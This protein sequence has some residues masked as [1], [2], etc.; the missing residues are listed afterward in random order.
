[1]DFIE[2]L[3]ERVNHIPLP[4]IECKTGY[5]GEEESF[6]V[7]PL[8][9]SRVVMEY[10]D[11]TT[12]QQLNFEFAMKSKLQSQIHQ[13]LWLV[14]SELE[15][16]K[17]LESNDGSFEFDE[18]VITNKPFINQKD[19]QGWFVFLLDVQATITVFKESE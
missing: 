1:M 7:Y 6:V 13:T 15:K 8:P 5:L 11:G 14:Q 3:V 2:R 17:E 9:G 4:S 12:D 18:L 16:L 10:M 19:D